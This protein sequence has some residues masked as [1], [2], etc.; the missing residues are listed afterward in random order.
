MRAWHGERLKPEFMSGK[1]EVLDPRR[2]G[3][4]RWRCSQKATSKPR[5]REP[6]DLAGEFGP[7]PRDN[8][9]PLRGLTQW[10]KMMSLNEE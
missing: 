6:R 7:G 9:K 4:M 2:Q 3:G 8:W 1:L 10:K 5:P